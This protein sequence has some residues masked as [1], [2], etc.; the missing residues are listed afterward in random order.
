[1]DVPAYAPQYGSEGAP[2]HA[3]W[4]DSLGKM[5]RQRLGIAV[6]T[7]YEADRKT[8]AAMDPDAP[9]RTGAPLT[10]EDQDDEERLL[11]KLFAL[12]RTGNLDRAQEL[13]RQ[14]GQPWRA[15]TLAGWCYWHDPNRGSD[16]TARD[17]AGNAFR[18]VFKEACFRMADDVSNPSA[19]ER[20]LYA[21]LSGNLKR[22][23]PVCRK[24]EDV[25][26]AHFRVMVDVGVEKRLRAQPDPTRSRPLTLPD[27]YH[28]QELDAETVF[29]ALEASPVDAVREGAR[30]PHHVVQ[31]LLITSD[32]ATLLERAQ[33]WVDELPRA[34]VAPYYRFLAHLVLLL[35]DLGVVPPAGVVPASPMAQA[36]DSI[37]G[38]YVEHLVDEGAMHVVADY[39]GR[40]PRARQVETYAAFLGGVN[41]PT[42]RRRC[43]QLAE[44]AGLPVADITRRVVELVRAT[45]LDAD[46]ASRALLDL[47]QNGAPLDP[48]NSTLNLPTGAVDAL[49]IDAMDWLV[50]DPAQRGEALKQGNAVVREFLLARKHEAA[51]AVFAKIPKDSPGVVE[52]EW[53]RVNG[54]SQP[55]PAALENARKEYQC[56]TAFL[57]AN[58][59]YEA[60]LRQR[61]EG[62]PV[63]PDNMASG[64]GPF[65]NGGGGGSS[66]MNP[67]YLTQVQ[68]D[69]QRQLYQQRLAAWEAA[70]AQA[71]DLARDKIQNVLG[72]PN[73]WL[74]DEFQDK[75]SPA[76]EPEREHQ[77]VQLRCMYLPQLCFDLHRVFHEQGQYDAA[78]RLADMVV[79]HND[80]YGLLDAFTSNPQHAR[81]LL[82]L[83]RKSALD[84]LRTHPGCSDPLA[85]E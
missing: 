33:G 27:W 22:L 18:D 58:Y 84:L 48:V 26:W 13:C 5:R 74:E 11:E 41:D 21:A 1:M 16:V 3:A 49:K 68:A 39:S 52:V 59:A 70:V 23:L 78:I 10:P 66:R 63:A 35:R 24:W 62:K 20:A 17:V 60:W 15:T 61:N 69:Q 19:Y 83:V 44:N 25:L 72:F 6:G 36:C 82:T 7:S 9:R 30:E 57:D 4:V 31:Q 56:V 79:A 37:V 12:V 75:G 77:L 67:S 50:M 73:G 45:P 40:L 64:V 51:A 34:R 80:E 85:Y 55:L 76:S 2:R 54:P 29:G 81:T 46:E 43:L 32:A 47:T 28:E 38:K 8:V 53:H 71:A 14:A 65:G 42:Q